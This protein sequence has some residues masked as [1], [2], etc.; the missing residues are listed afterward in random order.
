MKSL[1]LK[2]LRLLKPALAAV[3]MVSLAGSPAFAGGGDH[4]NLNSGI[5]PIKSKPYGQSYDEW[6]ADWWQW[7]LSIPA[8]H[9]PLLDETGADAAQGQ[10][11]PVWFLCGV[12]NATGIAERNISVP[13]GKALFFPIINFSWVST[14][15]TDPQTAEAIRAI[16]APPADAATDLVCELDGD[17]VR[18][19][20]GYRTES[21]L[22]DVTLPA[23][24]IFGIDAGTYGP[25]MDQGYYLM[26]LPL[27]P[28]KHCLHFHGSQPDTI[29]PYWTPFTMDITYHITVGQPRR[30]RPGEGCGH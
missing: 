19:L 4:G 27:E 2:T 30:N 12:F 18:H 17:S 28:G 15:P 3:V 7:A 26:M 21:P 13:E 24:N 23:N 16:I 22:F 5:A 25:S 14:L 20:G 6:T 11:G 10:A 1:S 9:N 29:A 8:D